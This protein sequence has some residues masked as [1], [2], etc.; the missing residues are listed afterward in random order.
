[1]ATSGDF[2]V[3]IDSRVVGA[4]GGVLLAGIAT[5]PTMPNDSGSRVCLRTAA[6]SHRPRI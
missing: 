6:R 4:G 5:V 3:A 1:M 2:Y